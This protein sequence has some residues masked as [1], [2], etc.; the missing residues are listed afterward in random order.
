[1]RHLA[2]KAGIPDRKP[3][4]RMSE[5]RFEPRMGEEAPQIAS[6]VNFVA[7]SFGFTVVPALIRQIS[8]EGAA[9]RPLDLGGQATHE[10]HRRARRTSRKAASTGRICRRDE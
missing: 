8:V 3:V 4:Q 7:A 2:D 9:C 5:A 10:R 6:V 1:M